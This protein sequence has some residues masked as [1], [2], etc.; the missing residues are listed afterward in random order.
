MSIGTRASG[1][2]DPDGREHFCQ[3]M[4]DGI[5]ELSHPPP[6]GSMNKGIGLGL[7]RNLLVVENC[8]ACQRYKEYLPPGSACSD[9]DGITLQTSNTLLFLEPKIQIA[10]DAE[11]ARVVYVA[12][13]E[14][15]QDGCHRAP[16][17]ISL[18][19]QKTGL[20]PRPLPSPTVDIRDIS[21][22]IELC[23]N[24]HSPGPCESATFP[25]LP[26]LNLIDVES[27]KVVSYSRLQKS[28]E[29]TE[30]LCL[31]YVWGTDRQVIERRLRGDKLVKMPR[32]ISDAMEVTRQLGKRY[33]WVDSV[34]ASI[35]LRPFHPHAPCG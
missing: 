33:L 29:K 20:S 27:K 2:I 9:D 17:A 19:G 25:E 13:G 5:Y 31:S 8:P 16:A 22:W 34:R 30:Y 12:S 18:V 6:D 4:E 35:S 23:A 1:R 28:V 11:Y 26:L 3:M 10:R 24:K 14:K 7:R 15:G 32:T 21:R